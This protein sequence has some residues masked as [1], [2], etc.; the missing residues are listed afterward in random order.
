VNQPPERFLAFPNLTL[1]HGETSAPIPLADHLRG[2]DVPGTATRITVRLAGQTRTIDLALHAPPPT[3][4]RSILL[5]HFPHPHQPP[6]AVV[7]NTMPDHA[8]SSSSCSRG[9]GY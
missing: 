3:S 1:A 6:P 5:F 8:S 9:G 4:W 7:T 2:P